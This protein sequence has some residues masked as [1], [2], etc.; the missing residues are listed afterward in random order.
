MSD[1]E[2]FES[3]QNKEELR[4]LLRRLVQRLT[5]QTF[6]T[7][8]QK[9]LDVGKAI[10][11]VNRIEDFPD[12]HVLRRTLGELLRELGKR[13]PDLHRH[14]VVIEKSIAKLGEESEES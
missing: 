7:P 2:S 3:V 5:K 9:Q 13:R 11:L 10:S 4:Q 6:A 1:N 12:R 8:L 14:V